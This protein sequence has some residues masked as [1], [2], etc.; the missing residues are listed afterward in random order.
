M[1]FRS[2]VKNKEMGNNISA[3]RL[4]VTGL[5][6]HGKSAVISDR[7]VEARTAAA[8]PGY[9]WHRLWSWDETPTVPNSGVEPAGPNHFPAPGGVRFIVFTVPPSTVATP[10]DLDTEAARIELEEKFPGR[11]AHMEDHQ[12]GL[13]TTATID[14]IY[15]ADGEISLELDDHHE[16]HLKTG[17]TLVQNGVRHAW[18]NHSSKPCTLIVTIFGAERG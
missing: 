7:S 15:V 16:V 17:D 11:L 1:L 10:D 14:F 9:G 8:V 3:K 4:I 12:T 6:V 5:D 13:H 2:P 18:R